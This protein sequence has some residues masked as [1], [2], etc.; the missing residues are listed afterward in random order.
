MFINIRL[1]ALIAALLIGVSN[2][3]MWVVTT[4]VVMAA[5]APKLSPPNRETPLIVAVT[6]TATTPASSPPDSSNLVENPYGL[7]ALWKGGDVVARGTII[8]LV[9]MSMGSWYVLFTRLFEQSK[10]MKQGR[11]ANKTFWTAG[12][13]QQGVAGL[14]ENSPF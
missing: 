7:E 5:D 4:P 2:L 10:L 1:S 6:G 13:I 11:D 14:N 3:A 12:S 8:I 9:L